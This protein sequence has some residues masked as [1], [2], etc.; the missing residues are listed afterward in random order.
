LTLIFFAGLA[1][2]LVL[3]VLSGRNKIRLDDDLLQIKD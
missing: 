1:L 3:F 2:G